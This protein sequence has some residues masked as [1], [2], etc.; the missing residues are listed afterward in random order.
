[1]EE[2]EVHF[3]KKV[4]KS[5]GMTYKELGKEIGYSESIL[6]QSV[7]TNKMS[8]QLN[9]VLELYLET[10]KLKEEKEESDRIKDLLRDLLIKKD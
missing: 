3:I 5:L 4:A 8:S 1:M 9:R 2:K 6:R 10:I 7:S